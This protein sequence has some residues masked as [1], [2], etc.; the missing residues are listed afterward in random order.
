M[1]RCRHGWCHVKL[2]PSWRL[3][4]TLFNHVQ[5]NGV[6]CVHYSTMSSAT[7][8]SVYTIQPC[9]V[10]RCVLCTLFNHVQCNGVFCVHYSTM[11]NVTSLHAKPR[12]YVACVFKCN[13]HVALPAELPDL[14]RASAVTRERNRQPNRV[15]TGS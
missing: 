2:L 7:V 11:H 12:T 4:Y 6:F 15:N 3:L 5:C 9:P 14:L 13:L 10:Q 1:L 8:C